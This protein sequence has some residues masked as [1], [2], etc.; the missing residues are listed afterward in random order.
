MRCN[1]DSELLTAAETDF[2]VALAFQVLGARRD[3]SNKK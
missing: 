2:V 1:A 3:I